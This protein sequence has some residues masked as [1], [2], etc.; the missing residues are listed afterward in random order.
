[1]RRVARL[2]LLTL[3]ALTPGAAPFVRLRLVAKDEAP[4]PCQHHRRIRAWTRRGSFV[5]TSS[6]CLLEIGGGPCPRVWA[7]ALLLAGWGATDIRG[8]LVIEGRYTYLPLLP[9][10]Q[11]PP[12]SRVA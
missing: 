2:P 6:T 8:P 7:C 3:V 5:A 12:C 1:M 10:V 9:H 4:V 11:Y